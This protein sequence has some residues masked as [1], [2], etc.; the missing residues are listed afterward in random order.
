MRAEPAQATTPGRPAEVFLAFLRLGCTSFGGPAAHLGYF[1]AEF[2]ERRRWL[3]PAAFAELVA[4]SQA[5]PGPGSS[6]VGFAIGLLHADLP[7]A[8]AAFAGFT[9][10]SAVLMLA[11]A[12]GHSLFSGPAGQAILRGLELVAVA[13]VAQAVLAMQRTLAPDLARV[14]FALAAIPL[15]L[16]LPPAVA[17]PA[18]LCLAAC[19]GVLL[20]H[21]H[22][23]P[24]PEQPRL[25]A[26]PQA[27]RLAITIFCILFVAS[28][29]L[30]S[31]TLTQ[32]SLYASLFRSGALVFGGGHVVLPLL[33]KVIVARGWMPGGEFL[34]GYGAAQALPGPLFSFAAFIGADMRALHWPIL[35][36]ILALF[37]LFAPGLLLMLAAL[38]FWQSLRRRP[39]LNAALA[40]I[41]AAV[42]GVLAAALYRPIWTSAIHSGFDIT[43]AACALFALLV[44]RIPSWNVV[45]AVALLSML[46]LLF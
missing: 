38:P 22:R 12:F 14:G 25:P 31:R 4:L 20:L 6:Q 19:A 17:A 27:A 15:M 34:A 18:T 5:L 8:L 7:G 35:T 44:W 23:K 13:I 40:G 10:P 45:L 1:Q 39:G 26:S 30:Q 42:V 43:L 36:G 9:I 2:V 41:N 46:R 24:A 21:A 29:V 28:L 37:A 16:F 32:V 3:T 11:F 33:D